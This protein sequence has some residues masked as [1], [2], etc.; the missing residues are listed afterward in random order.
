MCEFVER[1]RA[2]IERWFVILHHMEGVSVIDRVYDWVK[3]QFMHICRHYG[4]KV[5]LDPLNKR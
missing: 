1:N 5:G 2:G 4:A 3:G